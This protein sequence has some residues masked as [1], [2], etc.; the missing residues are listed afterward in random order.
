MA[1]LPGYDKAQV[2][3]NGHIV[4]SELGSYPGR[5][6]NFCSR[7]GAK[8]ITT[9]LNCQKPIRGASRYSNEPEYI[10]PAF[11]PDCGLPYPWTEAALKAAED[12][13]SEVGLSDTDVTELKATLPDLVS[14]S[15]QTTVAATRFR[16][17]IEKAG[18]L[19][20]DG[21][22]TILANVVT[23]AARKILFPS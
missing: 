13:A 1:G 3:L 18:P 7:C 8:T 19:A 14:D 11:C 16:R 17:I 10:P 4:N 23:E 5:T 12:L 22:K 6:E 20:P 9:C 21:V 2:C 15:P